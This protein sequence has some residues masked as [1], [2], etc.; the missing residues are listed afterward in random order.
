MPASEETVGCFFTQLDINGR[1][2]GV[3]V[4]VA[5][6]AMQHMW[7]GLPNPCAGARVKL[8]INSVEQV[9]SAQA[10]RWQR[11]PFP[12]EVL[13]VGVQ[14]SKFISGSVVVLRD[15]CLVAVG[16]WMMQQGSELVALQ[17][18]DLSISSEQACVWVRKAKN[19][20]L[21]C[22]HKIFINATGSAA[23]LVQLLKEWLRV[24]ST[25]LGLLF[26]ACSRWPLSTS[27][28]SAMCQQMVATAGHPA[29][30]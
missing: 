3:C 12:I 10:A 21:G 19:N 16:L 14:S 26:T 7:K 28:I 18:K 4:V 15:A 23:C 22:G 8:I 6:I 27:A 1:G 9:L 29:P 5:V 11:D 20:Q 2:G 24:R 25:Q 17:V 13:Q 30:W